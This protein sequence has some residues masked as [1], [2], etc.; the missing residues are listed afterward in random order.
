VHLAEHCEPYAA[1]MV[2][3]M[4]DYIRFCRFLR[5]LEDI[6]L[7]RTLSEVARRLIS[8]RGNCRLT[9]ASDAAGLASGAIGMFFVICTEDRGRGVT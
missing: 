5:Q 3:H 9:V 4:L 2:Q 8:A 1:L 6:V 7:E